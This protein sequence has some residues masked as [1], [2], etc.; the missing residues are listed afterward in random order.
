MSP[1]PG[2]EPKPPAAS[3]YA[4]LNPLE[5]THAR[6]QTETGEHFPYSKLVYQ[7]A[8]KVVLFITNECN[9]FCFIVELVIREKAWKLQ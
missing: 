2:I 9:Y 1:V 7:H 6:C 8:K 5:N 4:R 3:C